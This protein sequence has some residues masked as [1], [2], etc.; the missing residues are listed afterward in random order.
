VIDPGEHEEAEYPA[1]TK[2]AAGAVEKATA[3]DFVE[4]GEL[5]DEEA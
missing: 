5:D 3:A 1:A 2:S 4:K